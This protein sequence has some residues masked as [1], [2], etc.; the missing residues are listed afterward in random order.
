MTAVVARRYALQALFSY[1]GWMYEDRGKGTLK[2]KIWSVLV[3]VLMGTNPKLFSYQSSLPYLPV[4]NVNETITRYLRT[5]RPLLDDETYKR[6][7]READDFKKGIGK[8]LQRYLILKSFIASNYV[9]D[10]WEEYVYLRG[11]SPIM[12]NSNFYALDSIFHAPNPQASRAANCIVAALMHRRNLENENIQPIMVQNTVPLCT[13]QYD[14]QVNTTRIPGEVTDK[15]VHYQDSKHVAVY[16]KGKWYKLYTYY[17]SNPLNAKELELQIQKI[18]DD[19][20]EACK[21][22]KYLASLTAGDRIPWAQA[23]NKYFSKGLNKS[24]L[25]AI[26]KAAFCVILDDDAY[27][28][29]RVFIIFYFYYFSRLK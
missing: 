27:E 1:H 5:V 2:T 21:G 26:E 7:E 20:S 28:I 25:A 15:I 19:E 6:F 13:R 17:H 8:R 16:S 10:W 29:S 23:R 11:R 9:S 12:V 14:R 4:P 22:E 24:S 3:K 18:L